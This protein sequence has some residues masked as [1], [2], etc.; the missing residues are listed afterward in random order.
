MT[1]LEITIREA[2][3]AGKSYGQYVA[4]QYERN[5]YKPQRKINDDG[6]EVV[7][8]C[9]ICGKELLPGTR[10]T[11]KTCGGACSYELNRR[12][13]AAYYR[14]NRGIPDKIIKTCPRCG[15]EFTTT[16]N[17]QV[18]CSSECQQNRVRHKKKAKRRKVTKDAQTLAK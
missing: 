12:R 1:H 9:E 8:R 6:Q 15:K 18:Y 13:M 16:K 5:G 11:I 17:N 4:E 2:A 10:S 3:R 14:A 7:R